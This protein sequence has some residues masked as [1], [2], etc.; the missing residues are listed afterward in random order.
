MYFVAGALSG[1]IPIEIVITALC[2]AFL[3]QDVGLLTYLVSK[4]IVRI[5]TT[6]AGEFISISP[7]LQFSIYASRAF[8]GCSPCVVVD[9][10]PISPVWWRKQILL[11]VLALGGLVLFLADVILQATGFGIGNT[12]VPRLVW[13]DAALC[14]MPVRLPLTC[15]KM[16]SSFALFS[17]Y[18]LPIAHC[19]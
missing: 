6:A 9:A 13:L 11:E 18:I 19:P 17:S 4:L 10:Q 3:E 16:R 5:I 14:V 1:P 2:I 12:I 8:S 15:E 7:P